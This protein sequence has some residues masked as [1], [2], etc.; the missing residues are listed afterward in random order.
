METTADYI[1]LALLLAIVA[2]MVYYVV[3]IYKPGDL[4]RDAPVP[5]GFHQRQRM[6]LQEFY[7]TY[8]LKPG[9]PIR[10]NDVQ[11]GLGMFSVEA[12]VPMELL[13][14]TDRLSDFGQRGQNV[15]SSIL[16]VQL[17]TTIAQNP[18]LAGSKLETVDDLIQLMAKM[19]AE[20]PGG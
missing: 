9:S 1:V 2:G 11:Q 14:P 8:Y 6:E 19:E 13:R 4:A 7:E 5:S 3:R 17:Q 16:T 10:M 12:R 15:L 20:Q 18:K